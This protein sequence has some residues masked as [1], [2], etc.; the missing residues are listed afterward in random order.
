MN[1]NKLTI[2]ILLAT[3]I[4]L[5]IALRI[6]FFS[7][8]CSNVPAFDDECKIALQAKQIARGNLPLLILAS[9]YIFPLDAYLMAPI[10]N[11]LPRNAFGARIMAFCFGILSLIFCILILRRMGRLKDTWPGLLLLLF[12]SAYLFM[13]QNGCA[14]PTYAIL[15]LLA[16]VSI[17]MVQRQEDTRRP[18]ITALLAGITSGLACSGTMLSLPVL[19]AVCAMAAL[20]K[21]WRK[22]LWT[23][24]AAAIGALAGLMPHILATRMC[25]GAFQAVQQSVSFHTAIHKLVSPVLDRTLPAALGVGIPIF[26]DTAERIVSLNK[27]SMWF[28]IIWLLLL[29]AA[30]VMALA[31]GFRRWWVDRFPSVDSGMAFVGISWMCFFLF[32]LSARSHSHTYRYFVPIAWSFPFLMAYLYL[33]AGRPWRILLGTVTLLFVAVNLWNMS[34]IISRWAQ[35]DF[36]NYLK[37]YDLKPAIR[38]LDGKGISRCHGTYADAYRITYETD[39]RVICSQPYNERFA[40][41]NVPFREIVDA[42]TNMAYVLSDT[43]KFPPAPFEKDLCTMRVTCKRQTCG[44]YEVYTDFQSAVRSDGRTIPQNF[45]KVQTSHNPVSV[46]NMIDGSAATFWRS[47]G[48]FQQTGMWV[49]VEWNVPRSVSRVRMDHGVSIHD[50]AE[51]LTVYYLANGRWEKIPGEISGRPGPFE[52]RNRHPTY[53]RVITDVEL[54]QP[55]ETTCIKIEIAKPRTKYAWTIA[56][57]EVVE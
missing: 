46:T 15:I 44:H 32:L 26:P 56:E 51:S 31:K 19:V 43:Y 1:R 12:G 38:Y 16:S 36:A 49:S 14:L 29:A 24:P 9:P 20:H 17:W 10:I 13:L 22:T 53:G 37:L 48:T 34:A 18:W 28:G 11:F 6:T 55:V 25:A 40:G 39:E 52:F 42:S 47:S 7:I 2:G 27:Y 35:P 30:T 23:L 41:W 33:H 3:A 57:I 21:Q 45:L 4:V 50:F 54:P 5:C 8:S